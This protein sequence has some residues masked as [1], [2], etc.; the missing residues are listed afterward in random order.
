MN[1]EQVTVGMEVLIKHR[2]TQRIWK[3]TVYEKTEKSFGV[4]C[5]LCPQMGFFYDDNL[6]FAG[7][8]QIVP[9]IEG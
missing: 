9:T 4:S 6:S 8:F 1:K 3:G 7:E 5:V 2:P